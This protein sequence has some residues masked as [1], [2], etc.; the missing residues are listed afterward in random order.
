MRHCLLIY[1]ISSFLFMSS[2]QGYSQEIVPINQYSIN[3]Q[4]RVEMTISS[5]P[6]SYYILKVRHNETEEFSQAVHMTLGSPGS[7]VITESLKAY[8]QNHYQVVRYSQLSPGD[9]DGDGIDDLQEYN[10]TPYQNPLNPANQIEITNGLVAINS[11][12]TFN[13]LAI[14]EDHVQWSEFLNGMLYA[15]FIVVDFLTSNPKIY[16]INTKN[17][18]L[19]E[20]FSTTIGIDNV[21]DHVRRGQVIFN[22]SSISPNGTLGNFS[23]NFSGGTPESFS[24]VQKTYEL[25]GANMPFLSNNL[26]YLITESNEAKYE[27][28]FNLYENSRISVLHESDLYADVN[29]W[30][31]HPA[32][33]Y[34]FFR[35]VALG[36][37]PGP[38]DIVLYES[39]PNSLPRIG[40][41]MTSAIQTPLSHVNLR[42]IQNNIPNA[43]IRD[44]LSID[45]IA[46]LLNKYIYF[47]V[48]QDRYIIK[49]ATLS[50]VNAWYENIRPD[51]EQNPPLNLNYTTIEPLSNISFDMFD[52]FGAKCS[53]MAVLSRL[54]FPEGTIPDGY[55]IPFYFYM[56]FMHFNHFFEEIEIMLQNEDFKN[57][58]LV[59]D[60]MLNELR[61]RIKSAPMPGWMINDLTIMQLSFPQNTP[62]RC[63]SSTN[64]EDL[65]GFNGAG[66]YSSK[67]QHP[68][69]GHISKSIKQV[70]AS[71]WNLR[72]FEE[73]D[74]YR[75]NHFNSA[76]GV[77]CHPNFEDE[78]LN[79][80]GVS[81]D[82]IYNT[83]NTFYFNSQLGEELI[84]NP[85]ES[86]V[87]EE[88]LVDKSSGNNISYI[89]VQRSNLAPKDSLLF[90]EHY[91]SQML[92]YLH[93][94]HDEFA[95]LY[96]AQDNPSFAMDIEYKIDKNGQ[97][98]IK[99][100][101]P[102]V[103]FIFQD[104]SKVVGPVNKDLI[105]IYPNPAQEYVSVE[106]LDDQFTQLIIRDLSGKE[107]FNKNIVLSGASVV[108]IHIETLTPGIYVASGLHRG[109]LYFSKR[110]V[111]Q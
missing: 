7:T 70:Y 56:E 109:R 27:E 92:E 95:I 12:S 9:Y 107:V 57:N 48:E 60:A 20:Q 34:G 88:I 46:N 22:P 26:S 8:P 40:G 61:D 68:H 21:G 31:L 32:E 77:L 90:G 13:S 74:F 73:R 30:G 54:G 65:P 108:N 55:G 86:S 91:L 6:L 11:F 64:N 5:N 18:A 49:E 15:K 43:Y 47:K 14:L 41:I 110:F 101:R 1:F 66:L 99:Q 35:E 17:H 19:H 106:F 29:Y 105:H 33:G 52:G 37:I 76:M 2:T 16:F 42:A 71:L 3:D 100:A 69:E 79:G 97:L 62:I 44:P 25:L 84:T 75:V 80:V 67:T 58:R 111:K 93:R 38:K 39:I 87:P 23:F 63:R 98:V 96:K 28:E 78:K 81:S 104:T 45:S 72:A 59:R 82:P 53:N 94:I 85:G 89:V 83:E 10:Q 24:S 50:E 4:G 36:E 102:W 51:Q 103:S